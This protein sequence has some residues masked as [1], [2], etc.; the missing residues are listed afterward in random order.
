MQ[1]APGKWKS[2]LAISDQ[3]FPHNHP[4]IVAFLAECKS[5]LKPDK[6]VNVGDETDGHAMSFH[7]HDPDLLSP[8]KEL[9]T[10]IRRLEPIY[11]LFPEMDLMESNHGSLVFRRGK[12]F[13][14]PRHV[15]K[16]YRAILEAPQGWNWHEYLILNP[17]Q[18]APIFV[19]HGRSSNV[20]ANSKNVGMN[21]IQGHHHSK[22]EIQS[23]ANDFH[24]YWGMTVGCLID[25]KSI[26]YSYG[27]TL[28]QKP[29]IGLGHVQEGWPRLIPMILDRHGRWTGRLIL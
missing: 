10:A 17:T 9:E 15:F 4:D 26:A 18:G 3:H 20:L 1:V 13:G 16:S 5:K 12:A 14:I 19:C 11:K 29:I 28:N 6:V 8:G 22:F 21:F 7:E 25:R 27:K 24:L 2:I 23:W